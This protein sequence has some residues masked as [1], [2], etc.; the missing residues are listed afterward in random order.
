MSNLL[1]QPILA[2]R[3]KENSHI[4]KFQASSKSRQDNRVRESPTYVLESCVFINIP[5]MQA[6]QRTADAVVNQ[7]FNELQTRATGPFKMLQVHDRMIEVEDNGIPK[8]VSIDQ[9]HNTPMKSLTAPIS[10]KSQ[11][12][13]KL[14]PSPQSQ[15]NSTQGNTEYVVDI[16]FRYTGKK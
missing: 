15:K 10:P 14:N 16:V 11:R 2:L 4:R 8:T 5:P 7:T 6:N 12:Y 9:F 13:A 3:E 1:Q